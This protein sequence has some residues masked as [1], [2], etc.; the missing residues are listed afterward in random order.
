MSRP[1]VFPVG[2]ATRA[3]LRQGG[4]PSR[5][6]WSHSLSLSWQGF[7]FERHL[8]LQRNLPP[9]AP[10]RTDP[11]FILGL[12]RSGTT[13]LHELLGACPGIQSPA[14]WQCLSPAT[15]RLHSPPVAGRAVQ[16]PMDAKRIDALS[17]QEDE[18][19]LLALGVPSVYRGFFDP[20]RLP[21]LTRW[22]DRTTIKFDVAGV[23][24]FCG[25]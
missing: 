9:T 14:T 12:W 6:G 11:L 19:A 13:Y 21:E 5:A 23:N 4:K 18:F 8:S 20:R 25:E 3:W 24:G 2:R 22:L 1:L 10:L 17:P 16:R 15:I 7:W